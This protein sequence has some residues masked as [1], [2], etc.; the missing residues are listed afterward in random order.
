MFVKHLSKLTNGETEQFEGRLHGCDMK[1]INN[2][3]YIFRRE[4][5]LQNNK[6]YVVVEI[7]HNFVLQSKKSQVEGYET[8]VKLHNSKTTT[9]KLLKLFNYARKGQ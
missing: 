4:G 3:F 1:G 9:T 2:D 7:V 6:Q 8:K 5:L